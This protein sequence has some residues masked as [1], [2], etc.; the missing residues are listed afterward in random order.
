VFGT[1]PPRRGCLAVSMC[2]LHCT[3]NCTSDLLSG[4]RCIPECEM[5]YRADGF[6]VCESGKMIGETFACKLASEAT[7]DALAPSL[8]I[9]PEPT[10]TEE[11][12]AAATTAVVPSVVATGG[13]S[14][15]SC[16]R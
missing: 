3:E 4:A 9:R 2:T 11:A 6:L 1:R 13:S 14:V 7:A 15:S 10:E 8:M 16:E 5:G 12:V